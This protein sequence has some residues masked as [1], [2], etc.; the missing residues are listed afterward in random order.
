VRTAAAP[1]PSRPRLGS[2]QLAACAAWTLG[3]N[4]NGSMITAAPRLYPHMWS[5]DTAFISIGLAHLNV[6]R[7]VRELE[8]LLAAQWR[9]GML[10][11]IVFS[12]GGGYFPG[13]ERW[14][15]A[16]LNADAPDAPRTS[17]ICQPPVHAIALRRIVDI[18]AGAESTARLLAEGWPKLYR[19]HEWLVRHRDPHGTGMISIVHGWESGMDNSPRWDG[20][21]SAVVPGPD[22]PPYVR[23]DRHVASAAERP[24][25][26]EYDRYLWLVEEMRKVR[27]D[28]AQ[29]VRASSFLVGDVFVTAVFALASEVLATLGEESGQPGWQVKQLRGWAH[30]SRQAVVAA[31]SPE[32][33]LAR[34]YDLRADAW[35]T[36]RTIAGFAPLLCGGLDADVEAGMLAR[37]LGPDWA[38]HP[39]LFAAIPPSVS[40]NDPAFRPREYWRGPVW[41]VIAWLFGWA[42]EQRGWTDHAS[43]L[44]AE[45]LRLTGDGA[46]GE[47]YHPVT[48]EPLGSRH[49][50]WTA[51]VVLDWLHS[52]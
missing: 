14:G 11:H 29:V 41:P 17:G 13:P 27:Y 1:R 8:T 28:A 24:S 16:E 35:L 23:L 25:D 33:G 7:A 10:P 4:D 9:N 39:D 15:A 5:W 19:W 44:R 34:D 47:Y 36:T 37:I 49:Q 45:C 31:Y 18:G 52:S 12:E 46:F 42:F 6:D 26:L 48:G 50:S 51:T 40:P 38:G 21:Y 30:R 43:R 3:G 2:V 32:T 22:L 20:P